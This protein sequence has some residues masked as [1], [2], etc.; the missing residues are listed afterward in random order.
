M[1]G[2]HNAKAQV[3]NIEWS[4]SEN[5]LVS[6]HG[7]WKNSIVV[8]KYPDM[9][10]IITLKGHTYRVLYLA[11]SP[12]GE[13]IVTGA[14]GEDNTLRFWKVFDTIKNVWKEKVSC[15]KSSELIR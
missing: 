15:L 14:G 1:L 5:E 6:S 11:M 12:N 13:G 9:E 3:C 10:K 4:K 7:W 8:W 2:S